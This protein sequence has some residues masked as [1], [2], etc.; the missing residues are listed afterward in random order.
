ML[1][2]RKTF[3][4]NELAYFT[5][6]FYTDKTKSTPIIPISAAYPTFAIRSPNGDIVHSGTA[7]AYSNP[8]VYRVEWTIPTDAQ[9]STD[10][11]NWVVEW[12]MVSNNNRQMLYKENFQV[13]DARVETPTDK[14]I[15]QVVPDNQSFRLVNYFETDPEFIQL[16]VYPSKNT[17]TPIKTFDKSSMTGPI[18]E[19]GHLGYYVDIKE[20]LSQGDYLVM[21]SYRNTALSEMSR[22][23]KTLRS[24]RT[25]ILRYCSSLRILIDRF[26]KRLSAPN[27]YSDSDLIEF[28]NQGCNATNQWYPA[29]NPPVTWDTVDNFG[30]GIYVIAWA[31]L[32]GLRSQH[33]L[34]NDLAF[35]YN[36]QSTTLDYDRTGG[37]DSAITGLMDFIN[38]GLSKAKT[39]LA[40]SATVGGVGSV[41]VRPYTIYQNAQNMVIPYSGPLSGMGDSIWNLMVILGL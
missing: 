38:N 29:N 18:N 25:T 13:V 28:L 14:S 39:A 16:D 21:W 20:G 1:N 22:E 17:T 31:A 24:V 34:E 7:V 32:W 3:S 10:L 11:D 35:Q 2:N 41:F 4:R 26:Q 9:L 27:S 33:L 19:M 37:I 6:G 8:G 23:F 40:R 12:T 15:I 30:L 36:G 5:A